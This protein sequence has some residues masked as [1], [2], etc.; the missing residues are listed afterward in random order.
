MPCLL[1]FSLFLPPSV[2]LPSSLSLSPP[3]GPEAGAPGPASSQGC[4]RS[5]IKATWGL[6]GLVT[7]NHPGR[8]QPQHFQ[9]LKEE[10]LCLGPQGRSSPKVTVQDG[11]VGAGAPH[12]PSADLAFQ[13][14]LCP[15]FPAD[16]YCVLFKCQVLSPQ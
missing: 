2:S 15:C 1:F 4:P 9:G 8:P 12:T 10:G 3:V 7:A 5:L 11:R 6:G 16:V 13:R 14:L